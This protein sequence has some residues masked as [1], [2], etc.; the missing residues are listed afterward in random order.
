MW[1]VLQDPTSNQFFRLNDAAYFF[2]A[3]LDGRRTVSGVW[4]VCNE[5]LGDSAPTQGE[6]IQLLGQLY[7][8]NLLQGEMPPD[9][10]GLL[11]RF[12]KRRV[13]EVQ[14]KMMNL[15]FIHIPL[16]DPDNILNRWVG[17]AGKLFTWVGMALWAV[18]VS[19][20]V[21]FVIG[22]VGELTDQAM[23]I[24]AP[25]NLP[26]L[27]LGI[28]LAKVTHEFGHGFACKRFGKLAGGGEV[29]VMGIMFLVFTPLPYVD[30]SSAWAFRS[31]WHRII[32]GTAGMMVEIAIASIAAIIWANTETGTVHA[33]CYNV[34][35]IASISTVL[36]NANPLLRYDGYY[37]LS[38]LLE[39]P[40]LAPR[41]RQYIY[42][43]VKKYLWGVRKPN[44]PAHTA[45]EK[46]WF[47]FYGIASTIYR[48][49]ICVGI[50]LMVSRKFFLLGAML[51]CLAV[52]AWV[53]TPIGKFIRYLATSGELSRVRGRAVASVLVFVA[54]VVALVGAVERP[55]RAR[56]DGIV[57]VRSDRLAVVHAEVDG[58]LQ[59]ALPSGTSVDPDDPQRDGPLVTMV[60]P[61]LTAQLEQLQAEREEWEVRR[62][63][64]LREE[65]AA[66]QA[67]TARLASLDSQIARAEKD[68]ARLSPRAPLAGDWLSPRLENMIGAYVNH[69][70]AIGVV[71]D[72]G[73]LI[74]RATV[75]Q[76][77]ARVINEAHRAEGAVSIR[78]RGRPDVEMSGTIIDI[79]E[80][81]QEELPSPSLGFG[82][83]GGIRTAPDDPSGT[84]AAERF[85]EVIV[86][87]DDAEDA[88]LMLKQR[89]VL[90]F[91]LSPKPLAVQWWRGILQLVQ[92]RFH[93]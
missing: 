11:N 37:I 6:A 63:I 72:T 10:A 74:F 15:M 52:F 71:V 17:I 59:S 56:A 16:F 27:Y 87:P 80:A 24:L 43:L 89:V 32:V 34:M 20:G 93:I 58:F 83:G 60:N 51:A 40:N 73:D 41:S 4:D 84:K 18:L 78:L 70:D 19:A 8:S 5:K 23:N 14:G 9:A 91:E 88:H 53:L 86:R 92:R 69:G 39:I 21:Y 30:A 47:V 77:D 36:F 38:D 61:V 33:V 12:R 67:M 35:F 65:P 76:D 66:A 85:F 57:D 7:T 13:R 55:D 28:V 31:K 29:H 26:L 22:R 45:G 75:T 54:A 82:A 46:G 68:L 79:I 49:I 48:V 44:S 25:S 2:V 42:Y 64:A 50:L 62:Q 1:H 90:R 3:M 81:G